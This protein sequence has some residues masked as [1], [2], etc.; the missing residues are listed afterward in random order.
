MTGWASTR[1]T[2]SWNGATRAPVAFCPAQSCAPVTGSRKSSGHIGKADD[3]V[4]ETAIRRIAERAQDAVDFDDV[5]GGLDVQ[6]GE[7]LPDGV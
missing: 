7:E 3:G 6:A 5:V 2:I 4:V 1:L